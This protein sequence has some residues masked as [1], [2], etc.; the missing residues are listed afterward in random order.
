MAKRALGRPPASGHVAL[1]RIVSFF[2]AAD[3]NSISEEMGIT[4]APDTDPSILA[5]QWS[6]AF[7][8]AAFHGAHAEG[9]PAPPSVRREYSMGVVAAARDLWSQL[10][11]P[12]DVVNS[13]YTGE[14]ERGTDPWYMKL[15]DPLLGANWPELRH[16]AA[17]Y[18]GKLSEVKTSRILPNGAEFDPVA[19]VAHAEFDSVWKALALAPHALALI[20]T[21]AQGDIDLLQGMAGSR[22]A[23]RDAFKATLYRQ[24]A[25]KFEQAFGFHPETGSL[26]T[27]ANCASSIWAD[28]LTNLAAVR[29]P[30]R[31]L[32]D[33][34]DPAARA[35][36]IDRHPFVVAVRKVAGQAFVTKANDLADGWN[37]PPFDWEE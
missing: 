7:H 10:G 26:R 1:G 17:A 24:L 19:M 12:G 37:A 22:G 16:K 2:D 4:L 14:M 31:I 20:A 34:E 8:L 30:E 13:E 32:L 15:L 35:E 33:V 36:Q 18:S 3:V 27:D 25:K 23:H 28:R 9:Y 5:H 6:E 29:V 11:L 21:L